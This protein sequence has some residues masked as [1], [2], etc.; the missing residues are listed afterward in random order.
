MVDLAEDL[1]YLLINLLSD[2]DTL[3]SDGASPESSLPTVRKE[4]AHSLCFKPLSYSDLTARLTERVQDHAKLQETLEAMTKYRPPEGLHDT[5]L[6]ELKDEYLNELDPYNSHFSKNQRDEAENIYKKWL[7][8][9]LKKDPDDVVL[10]PKLHTITSQ[11]YV[12]LSAVCASILFSEVI[13]RSLVF[14]AEGYKS[15]AGVTATKAESFL[16][17]VLQLALIATLEDHSDEDS[18]GSEHSSFVYKAC[19][20]S[21]PNKMSLP[22]TLVS[23]LHRIWL[24]DDYSACRS[25]I[26]HILR[27]FNQK[28]PT[29]FAAATKDLVFPAG[30]FDTESPANIESELEAKRLVN[31]KRNKRALDRLKEQQREFMEKQG[32]F[33]WN[34]K[35]KDTPDAE[36]PSSTETRAWNFP[37][38]LCIQCREDTSD[39]KLYGTF[40]MITDGH[41]F[42]ETQPEQ[43]DFVQEVL[44]VPQ[45]LDRTLKRDRPF[46]VAGGNNKLVSQMDSVGNEVQVVRQGI[47]KGWPK[48]ATAKGPLTS[49]CGHIM[50]FGCFEHYY[51]SVLRRHAQQVARQHP[52]RVTAQEFVCPLCKALANTF[53]PIVWKSTE[54]SYPATL[55]AQTPY[56]QFVDE[57]LNDIVRSM[58]S[59]GQKTLLERRHELHQQNL[60]TFANNPLKVALQRSQADDLETTSIAAWSEDPELAPISELAGVYLRL[61][62]PLNILAR[63][64][65]PGVFPAKFHDREEPNSFHLLLNTLA[66]TI[67]ATE[68]AFRGREAEFGT[69]SLSGIP[70]QTLSHLQILS[71]T[72][73]SYA[74]MSHVIL[75][76]GVDEHFKQVHDSMFQ[77]LFAGH[78]EDETLERIFLDNMHQPLLRV[79]SFTY[80]VHATMVLCP[81]WKIDYRHMLQIALTSEI[82]RVIVAYG[83]DSGGLTGAA[84]D[85]KVQHTEVEVSALRRVLGWLEDRFQK[86]TT[87]EAV[88][89]GIFES[90]IDA[91][92]LVALMRIIDRYALAFLRKAAMFFHVALGVDFPTTA[93]S[94]ASLP[95]LARLLHYMQLPSIVEI[96]GDLTEFSASGVQRLVSCWLDDLIRFRNEELN[97]P[98][99]VLRYEFDVRGHEMVIPRIKSLGIRLL[100]PAPLELIG[101]PKYYDVL[102]ELTSRRRCPNTG[103]E[104]SDPALCLFCGD[105]VCAQSVC[106][107]SPDNRGGCNAHVERCSAPIGMF[108]FVRKCNVVL[109]HAMRDPNQSQSSSAVLMGNNLIRRNSDTP[110]LGSFF[111]APYLTK[112]GETDGGLRNKHQLM[113]SQMR[114]DRMLRDAWLMVNGNVWSAIARKLEGEVNSGGWE[115]L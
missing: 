47:S 66:N 112:H 83:H 23:V 68:I 51:Q 41:L 76:G 77:K 31:Q 33:D 11:G 35:A 36:L 99:E 40:A 94:E 1:V 107:Q 13:F 25:K 14:V 84:Q 18:M 58:N 101:L 34:D 74:A 70:Q 39:A 56:A 22:Q 103:K 64:T 9:Q 7:G 67:A 3:T 71:S 110:P 102:L 29:C 53:L 16:Q 52:E 79:D 12:K 45:D 2:R 92:G 28:R 32:G 17:I 21:F 62:G 48:G 85:L 55:S 82:V 106:C 63:V 24:M 96:L 109:L 57:G 6:F 72:V 105:I 5:G 38:G 113:L 115:T 97:P 15:R 54:Q 81:L 98:D 49:S 89:F 88:A 27:I 65:Q 43:A 30:R 111:P 10:E 42:R 60:A 26:R 108:L 46:G 90:T 86:S 80:L 91:N 93:G 100:H 75:R 4:I 44:A 20:Y 95:E 37:S 114:Y 8:K 69:T 59:V 73:K 50:H 61:K 78:H 87:P 104:L 19:I